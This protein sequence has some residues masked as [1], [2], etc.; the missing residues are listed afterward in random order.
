MA[1]TRSLSPLN[2]IVQSVESVEVGNYSAREYPSKEWP[3][4]SSTST[5]TLPRKLSTFRWNVVPKN[6]R[7]SVV[8]VPSPDF[9]LTTAKPSPPFLWSH[10]HF[11]AQG[12]PGRSASAGS[13]FYDSPNL[14]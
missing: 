4:W 6:V 10:S 7:G 9:C 2:S 11:V 13:F 5:S 14:D 12:L 1:C 8:S 3:P